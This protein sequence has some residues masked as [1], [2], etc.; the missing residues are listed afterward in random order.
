MSLRTCVGVVKDQVR[1]MLARCDK[2]L[3]AVADGL[4]LVIFVVRTKP[5]YSPPC[6][7]YDEPAIC[8]LS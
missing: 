4:N 8:A 3:R 1:R 7:S 5:A 6:T 2:R